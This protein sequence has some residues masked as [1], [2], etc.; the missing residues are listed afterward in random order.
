MTELKDIAFN[1]LELQPDLMQL[2]GKYSREYVV[3]KHPDA[4]VRYKTD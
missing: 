4:E 1:K 2:I 3:E